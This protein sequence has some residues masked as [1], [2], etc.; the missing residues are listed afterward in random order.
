MLFFGSVLAMANAKAFISRAHV[1]SRREIAE[2]KKDTY[3][4]TATYVY[5]PTHPNEE[6]WYHCNYYTL[7]M[8]Y[9]RS[10]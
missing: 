8:R 10:R 1:L 7:D 6:D 4:Y 2:R 3:I 9:S 5:G